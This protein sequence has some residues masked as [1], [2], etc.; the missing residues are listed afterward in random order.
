MTLGYS[1]DDAVMRE[2]PA[3]RPVTSP[4]LLTVAAT[5]LSLVHAIGRPVFDNTFVAVSRN[6]TAGCVC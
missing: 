2:V 5:S 4:V 6:V 3:R 1:T